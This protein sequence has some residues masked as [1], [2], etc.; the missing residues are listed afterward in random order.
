GYDILLYDVNGNA[1]DGRAGSFV[2]RAPICA[3]ANAIFQA[4]LLAKMDTSPVT[5]FSDCAIVCDALMKPPNSWPWECEA[6]LASIA[7]KLQNADWISIQHCKRQAV[8]KA[9]TV[10]R[11][12]RD[13]NLLPNW[14]ET[15]A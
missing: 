15:L 11:L 4:V 9:D 13:N 2:C 14:M 12:A 1:I 3:E 7:A 5:I 10:A 8:R 6:T